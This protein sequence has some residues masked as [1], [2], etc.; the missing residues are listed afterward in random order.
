VAFL[1][2]CTAKFLPKPHDHEVCGLLVFVNMPFGLNLKFIADYF[3][4][5]IIV[6]LN[7]SAFHF[8]QNNLSSFYTTP[9]FPSQNPAR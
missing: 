1:L 5:K 7:Q 3:S 2:I 4:L 6:E 9:A 8:Y